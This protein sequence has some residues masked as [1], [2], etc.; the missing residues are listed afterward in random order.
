ML[1]CICKVCVTD[2][3]INGIPKGYVRHDGGWL[4]DG[5]ADGRAGKLIFHGVTFGIL[6]HVHLPNFIPCMLLAT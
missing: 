5:R 4:R 2:L 1:A 3:E 6:F